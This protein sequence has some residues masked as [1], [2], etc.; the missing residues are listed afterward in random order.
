MSTDSV[1]RKARLEWWAH[2]SGHEIVPTSLS[3]EH[4][5]DFHGRAYSVDL[6][7]VRVAEFAVSPMTARRTPAHI[8][9]H[10]PDCYQLFLVHGSPVRLEQRRNDSYLEAGDIALF[11]TSHPFA[12][13]FLDIGRLT[14]VTFLFM[15]RDALPLPRGQVERL[16]ARKLSART[17]AGAML[18]HYLTGLREHA[19]GCDPAELSRLGTISLDLAAT[20]LAGRLD[21]DRRLPVESR[22]RALAA[23]IDAFIDHR[24]GDPELGPAGIAAHHHISVRTLH[25]LFQRQ[26]ETVS[27]TIRRRRLERC[28]ADLADPRLRDQPIGEIGLRWGFRSAAEF[29]RAYRAAYGASPR[30]HRRQALAGAED[31]EGRSTRSPGV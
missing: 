5:D 26:P 27:A 24:L 2:M 19:A 4:A 14:R 17:G 28:H 10:D 15:P 18:A 31:G 7:G 22:H 13:D 21:A 8:R 29:S 12:T 3:T 30:D 1:P 6:A 23:R 25:V 9:R 11:D 16:L 20:F